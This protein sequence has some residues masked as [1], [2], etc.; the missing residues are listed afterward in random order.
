MKSITTFIVILVTTQLCTSQE[1]RLRRIGL[2]QGLPQTY[3][4]KISQ[5]ALGYIWIGTQDGLA[6]YD[7]RVMSV[8][9]HR[10]GDEASLPSSNVTQL[11]VG[12]GNRL[13]V[14]TGGGY[15]VSTD[16]EGVWKRVQPQ[17]VPIP[18][19]PSRARYVYEGDTNVVYT[20]RNGHRWIAT[21]KRGLYETDEKGTIV[22]QFSTLKSADHQLAS[23]D[24]WSIL[25]D[26]RGDLWVGTNG[27]GI[28][29][30]SSGRVKTTLRHHPFDQSSLSSDVVRVLFE[31]NIGTIWIGTHGGGVSQYDPYAHALPLLRPSRL[32]YGFADDGTRGIVQ[33][34]NGTLYV[35]LTTGIL[36][37][38]ADLTGAMKIVN[39]RER[40]ESIG[41]ARTLYL[42]K[43]GA[44]W[45]GTERNGIGVIPPNQHRI[46]WLNGGAWG[47]GQR[48]ISSITQITPDTIAIGTDGKI[49]VLDI[50]Q[51]I[52]T[53][54]TLPASPS[55]DEPRFP[56]SA[57]AKLS[58][59]RFLIGTEQGLL[60]GKLGGPY[61]SVECP[62]NHAA[63]PNINIIR[64]IMVQNNIAYVGTW[65]AGI[66]IVNLATMR[67][68]VIDRR[69]GLPS[70]MAYA[71]IPYGDGKLLITSNAGVIIWN[72]HDRKLEHTFGPTQGAQSLEFN[73]W[74]WCVS[75]SGVVYAGGVGGVNRIDPI[76]VEYAPPPTIIGLHVSKDTIHEGSQTVTISSIA[77]SSA[78]PVEYS[79]LVGGDAVTA[80]TTGSNEIQFPSLAPGNYVIT[81]RARYAGG[82]WGKP[83]TVNIHVAPPFW[84]TWWSY[85]SAAIVLSSV[86]WGTAT[87]VVRRREKMKTEREQMLHIER[88]RIA[89]DLHDDVGTGLAKIVILSENALADNSSNDV[90]RT[91]AET[92]REVI[93]SV[94]S[95]V[96]VM[97]S[98][99]D[100]L[101]AA[102]GYVRDTIAELFI[103]KSIAFTYDQNIQHDISLDLVVRR[104]IVLAMKECATNIV[105]HSRARSV[106][107]HV[108]LTNETI[109]ININDD[110]LGFDTSKPL[111]GS[112]LANM[113][114]RMLEIGG[115]LNVS[116]TPGTG[117]CVLMDIPSNS[118]SHVS[119]L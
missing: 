88:L 91:V 50:K 89:K 92:A 78:L 30:I 47:S 105:R 31:D 3:I 75:P 112:G 61:T 5:D 79:A 68:E 97:K 95:I 67:E 57:I 106:Q 22:S 8:Y 6:R 77:L 110:G 60:Q 98:S 37:T 118:K 38:A 20:T 45:V 7:G 72:I 116:S 10:Q 82:K 52:P 13:C 35:G 80:I 39:W 65:N 33:A 84:Q 21:S 27:G 74:S 43:T 44:L 94:R 109:R 62:D 40:Y 36:R 102:I 107:M 85:L 59:G 93:D 103:D 34:P 111:H 51:R 83:S 41:A 14:R 71:V 113:R 96:W 26:R 101:I 69:K 15:C 70:D 66:R 49:A 46:T 81:V 73:S 12:M 53:W 87:V 104:N 24:V 42:D 48:A 56:V 115:T 117:T 63:K 64:S 11:Y 25:E 108:S 23:N 114:E 32:D 19:W 90:S 2:E 76:H 17:D 28:S 86:V 4:N 58:D 18:K 1:L 119:T 9:R 29:I 55:Y 16:R 100:S 99:D 54:Y